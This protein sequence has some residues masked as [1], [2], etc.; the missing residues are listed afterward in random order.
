M[1]GYW[2]HTVRKNFSYV[3]LKTSDLL[4]LLQLTCECD[5]D[6]VIHSDDRCPFWSSSYHSLHIDS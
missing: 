1:V 4:K 6:A 3:N 2:N 5:S